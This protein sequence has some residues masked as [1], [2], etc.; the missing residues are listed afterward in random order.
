MRQTDL[1]N[2]LE[3]IAQ[4]G[5][6]GFYEGTTAEKI[7]AEMKA[8]NGVIGLADLKAYLAVERR[9]ISGNYR[10]YRI[11]SMPPPSSG[12][13]NVVQILNLSLIHI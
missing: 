9:P 3:R 13:A 4:Q 2:T 8:H 11:V 1:A 10:G 7:A 5:A 6:K 12:G